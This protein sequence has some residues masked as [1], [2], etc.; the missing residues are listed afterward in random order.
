MKAPYG[1]EKRKNRS[2]YVERLPK[3]IPT[4]LRMQREI[5]HRAIHYLQ[6]K[7]NIMNY[8]GHFFVAILSVLSW[9]FF[10]FLMDSLLP[11]C[12]IRGTP[13][14]RS[15]EQKVTWPTC[16]FSNFLYAICASY[17]AWLK[18][19]FFSSFFSEIIVLT[20]F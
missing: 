14:H 1:N 13:P 8:S 4:C 10:I 3:R 2:P 11:S 15:I 16:R 9:L 19:I 17:D 12:P 7:T 18:T 20:W 6:E 5:I